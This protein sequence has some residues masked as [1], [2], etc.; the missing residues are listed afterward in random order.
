MTHFGRVTAAVLGSHWLS[1][2]VSRYSIFN[3]RDLSFVISH[4]RAIASNFLDRFQRTTWRFDFPSFLSIARTTVSYIN[5]CCLLSFSLQNDSC[6]NLMYFLLSESFI[7]M[8]RDSSV[9]IATRYGLAGPG[10]ESRWG[11]DF[12]HTSRPVLGP[13]RPT[14]EWVP[15]LFPGGKAGGAWRW[16]P[17]TI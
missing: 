16:T 11:R 6:S 15:G 14:I 5:P 7:F 12:P 9:G 2:T 17:T 8:G 1:P 4:F 3:V 10:I 13:T